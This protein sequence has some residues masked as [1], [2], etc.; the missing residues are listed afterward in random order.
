VFFTESKVSNRQ[1]F[2]IILITLSAYTVTELPKTMARCSGT[3]A[4]VPL[5]IVAIFMSLSI[6]KSAQTFRQTDFLFV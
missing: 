2:F 6:P 1:L 4:W 3:G 5:L